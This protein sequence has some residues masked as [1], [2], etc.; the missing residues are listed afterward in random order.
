MAN[1]GAVEWQPPTIR[2][3]PHLNT[4]AT[5]LALTIVGGPTGWLSL[6]LTKTEYAGM[7]S[8]QITNFCSTNGPNVSVGSEVECAPREC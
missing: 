6:M 4:A 1:L 2:H 3:H 8:K 5:E 7:L